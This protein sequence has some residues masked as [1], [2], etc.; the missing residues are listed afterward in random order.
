M[1]AA[2]A[3]V[4]PKESVHASPRGAEPKAEAI[5]RPDEQREEE[6]VRQPQLGGVR[7]ARDRERDREL[8]EHL[9]LLLEDRAGRPPRHGHGV[10]G[11]HDQG[12]ERHPRGLL[13]EAQEE[14]AEQRDRG[15][16][17]V[18]RGD[19][20]ALRL[21]QGGQPPQHERP[22]ERPARAT[23]RQRE[24]DHRERERDQQSA[25]ERHLGAERHGRQLVGQGVVGAERASDD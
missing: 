19:V 23:Q 4:T 10:D 2:S 24:A 22:G 15:E 16:L 11:D 9:R 18:V 8:V 3:S 12:D 7:G 1:N 5:G 13:E 17:R 21:E 20:E 25:E 6:H 14:P